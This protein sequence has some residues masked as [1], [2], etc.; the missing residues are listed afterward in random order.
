MN[1]RH[2]H[3]IYSSMDYEIKKPFQDGGRKVTSQEPKE[4]Y[5][6]EEMFADRKARTLTCNASNLK[7]NG[8]KIFYKS[9]SW[10]FERC[11]T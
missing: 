5:N 1:Y 11:E 6:L 3:T 8:I 10:S 4:Y 7:Y 9:L 2:A